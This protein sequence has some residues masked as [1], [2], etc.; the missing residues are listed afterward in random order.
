MKSPKSQSDETAMS[1]TTPPL[2]LEALALEIYNVKTNSTLKAFTPEFVAETGLVKE[3]YLR[4]SAHVQQIKA[5]AH[6]AGLIEASDICRDAASRYVG[7]S[8]SERFCTKL[9]GLILQ[10]QNLLASTP[11]I[12]K[13]APVQPPEEIAQH[14]EQAWLKAAAHVH[15]LKAQARQQAIQ[16]AAELCA[17]DDRRESQDDCDCGLKHSRDILALASIPE[18][19]KVATDDEIALLI[20]TNQDLRSWIKTNGHMITCDQNVHG[21]TARCNCGYESVVKAPR[22]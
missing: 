9:R 22:K 2:E 10:R 4:L 16:E 11:E 5:Q 21:K 7:G 20:T 12:P 15:R 13:A 3:E 8:Q 14:P 18:I 1:E 6:Q 17:K 19:S